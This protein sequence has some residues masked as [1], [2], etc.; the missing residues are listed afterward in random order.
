MSFIIR[1]SVFL[2]ISIFIVVISWRSLGNPK[3][4]GFYRFF[5][6]ESILVLV[7]L[8]IPFW[9]KNPLSPI[10]IIAWILLLFS[11][12][13]VFQ[14]FYLLRKIGGHK[15]REDS[16]ETLAF[17]DT[18]NL[19]TDGIYQYIRH[20]LYSSLLLLAW[21]AYLKHVSFYGTVAVFLATAFLIATAKMEERENIVSFG[22]PYEAYIKKTKMFIPF[23]L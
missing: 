23:L 10:Q 21:G 16:S 2:V 17:E 7:L 20:P 4:H 5:A 18:A 13:F 22:A 11:A 8:N 19:V 12:I 1:A 3:C 6:F 9:F 15:A 14:G